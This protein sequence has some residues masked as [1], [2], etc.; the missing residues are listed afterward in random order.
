[1]KLCAC[2]CGQEAKRN[3]RRD[4]PRK[5]HFVGWCKYAEGHGPSRRECLDRGRK[6][7]WAKPEYR[8]MISEVASVTM[9]RTNDRLAAG[10]FPEWRRKHSEWTSRA[11]QQRWFDGRMSRAQ[12]KRWGIFRS[13]L[14][15]R[16]SLFLNVLGLKWLYE[17]KVFPITFKDKLRSYTPDFYLPEIDYWVE[18]KGF[19]RDEESKEKVE[20]F[21]RQYPSL[22]FMVVYGDR[23]CGYDVLAE[24]RH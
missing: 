1:V 18:T 13:H 23:K 3:N 2:G 16:F 20:T 22:N 24:N 4:G 15:L 10:E 14:E 5:G 19:W 21:M 9:K 7:N 12:H 6:T 17:S 11:T 8:K